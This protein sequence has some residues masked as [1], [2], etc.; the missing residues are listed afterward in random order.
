MVP[1]SWAGPTTAHVSPRPLGA[2]RRPG[3]REPSSGGKLVVR[4]IWPSG[5]NPPGPP[6]PQAAVLTTLSLGADVPLVSIRG[7]A[8]RAP[9]GAA[10]GDAIQAP[11]PG[12]APAVSPFHLSACAS[13]CSFPRVTSVLVFVCEVGRC[14]RLCRNHVTHFPL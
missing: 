1:E 7:A 13:G 4:P 12:P 8:T 3:A 14:H 10:A 6:A 9:W 11:K 5:R 2:E